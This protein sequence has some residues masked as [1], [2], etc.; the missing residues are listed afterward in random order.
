[1]LIFER[2]YDVTDEFTINEWLSVT[3]FHASSLL[4]QQ[5]H[6]QLKT[7]LFYQAFGSALL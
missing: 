5:F 1:M 3:V 7:Y 6:Y 4:H 2:S